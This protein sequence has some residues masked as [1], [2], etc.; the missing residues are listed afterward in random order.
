MVLGTI[1]FE[2]GNPDQG[3]GWLER[4]YE[5]HETEMS[6]LKM[7]PIIQTYKSDPRYEEIYQKMKFSDTG[8]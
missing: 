2:V 6:W 5:S 1:F 7:E 8:V 3:F 4:S